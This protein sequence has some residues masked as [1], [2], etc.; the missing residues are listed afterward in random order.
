ML[1]WRK[2]RRRAMCPLAR[3]KKSAGNRWGGPNEATG[4]TL[5][6]S[7]AHPLKPRK[8]ERDERAGLLRGNP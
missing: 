2:E 5:V 3:Q 6:A 7:V 4:Q 8:Q 1:P